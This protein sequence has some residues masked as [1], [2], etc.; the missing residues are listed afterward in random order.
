M[1]VESMESPDLVNI[2]ISYVSCSPCC[3][4]GM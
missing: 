1:F 2:D 3:L 4:G